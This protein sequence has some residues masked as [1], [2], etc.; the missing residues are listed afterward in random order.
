MTV[1][2]AE[3]R[4]T[5]SRAVTLTGDR[6]LPRVVANILLMCHTSTQMNWNP[7]GS[8]VARA[9]Q[10]LFVALSGFL[11][12]FSL[13]P[14]PCQLFRAFRGQDVVEPPIILL[15]SEKKDISGV[16]VLNKSRRNAII[17]SPPMP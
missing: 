9:S 15:Y 4:D 13:C 3:L 14:G 8:Q 10:L 17:K 6:N 2:T 1:R 16:L 11:S 5:L 12:L 7:A